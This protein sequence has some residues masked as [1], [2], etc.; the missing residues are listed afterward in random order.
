MEIESLLAFLIVGAIAGWLA[1]KMMK[2][3]GFGLLTNIV[4]GVIG[5]FIGAFV[6]GAVGIQAGGII[7][8]IVIATVGAG[9]LL[10]GVGLFK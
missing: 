1:G 3:G 6:F 5:A 4:V 7:G 9:I 10:F 8:S 2:G